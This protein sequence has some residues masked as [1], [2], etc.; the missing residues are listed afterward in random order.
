MKAKVM[1]TSNILGGT[2]KRVK[3]IVVETINS[4]AEKIEKKQVFEK[5]IITGNLPVPENHIRCIVLIDYKGMIDELYVGDVMDLPI[6]RY[7]TLVRRGF[8][9]K[10]EGPK[11]PN[12]QR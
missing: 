7:K 5:H 2:K 10:Y 6:R 9:K 4:T 12:K 1:T 8:V 3:P 11:I